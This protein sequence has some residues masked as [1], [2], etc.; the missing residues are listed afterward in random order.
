MAVFLFALFEMPRR[1]L[2]RSASVRIR[3]PAQVCFAYKKTR[4]SPRWKVIF[5]YTPC[6]DLWRWDERE[7]T[8]A[9]IRLFI[10]IFVVIM[11]PSFVALFFLNG[12]VNK[13]RSSG[14]NCHECDD[15]GDYPTW[16][17]VRVSFFHSASSSCRDLYVPYDYIMHE[18][19]WIVN[20]FFTVYTLNFYCL[21]R[22]CVVK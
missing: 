6:R 12:V 5:I 4:E 18:W 3:G 20:T 15:A 13:E 16:I 1:H 2:R 11:A 9:Y 19:G 22:N 17:S 21:F 14:A 10:E 8:D 7:K